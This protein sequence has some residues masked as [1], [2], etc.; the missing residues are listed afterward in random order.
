MRDTE[1]ESRE[2]HIVKESIEEADMDGQT[3]RDE[4]REIEG[5]RQI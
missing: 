1:L 5:E 4:G 3:D 2:K